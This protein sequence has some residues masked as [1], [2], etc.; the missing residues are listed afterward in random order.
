[1]ANTGGA[2]VRIRPGPRR[3][4][5]DEQLVIPEGTILLVLD[6]PRADEN[7]EDYIWWNV[8]WVENGTEGWV[9]ED[10]IAPAQSP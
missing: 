5:E 10:F 7:Q 2:G 3:S 9:V 6:G 8:R 1:V 4:A